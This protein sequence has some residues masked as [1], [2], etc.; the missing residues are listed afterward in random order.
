MTFTDARLIIILSP[1]VDGRR[2][3]DGEKGEREGIRRG[4]GFA[5]NEAH[6]ASNISRRPCHDASRFNSPARDARRDRGASSRY[7]AIN[8]TRNYLSARNVRRKKSA[9]VRGGHRDT[10][11]ETYE[12]KGEEET[13]V[14]QHLRG[15][16]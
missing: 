10:G 16:I 2:R 5:S 9:C 1:T 12:G 13:D 8:S 3:R 6:L 4:V 14:T 11:E 7:R 15:E